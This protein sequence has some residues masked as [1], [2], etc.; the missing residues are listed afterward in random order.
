MSTQGRL[1]PRQPWAI[2]RTT[3]TALH[4]EGIYIIKYIHWNTDITP[5]ALHH[6]N[7][8]NGRFIHGNAAIKPMALH[9][10]NIHHGGF[11]HWNT[12]ITPTACVVATFVMGD[13]F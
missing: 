13:L 7:I 4:H 11:I 3:P 9:G 6:Y 5:T 10:R 8:R 2:K 1:V 12:G